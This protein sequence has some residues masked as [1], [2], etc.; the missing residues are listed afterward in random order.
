M[1]AADHG[2]TRALA[3]Y[4]D[5]LRAAA[6]I[7]GVAQ[8]TPVLTSRT[9][10]RLAGASFSFKAENLQRT[11]AFK[12]R[13]AYNAIAAL[14]PEQRRR[15]VV[16]YSSGNHAQAMACAG[17]LLGVPTTVIM[18]HDAPHIKVAATQG[19]GAKVISYDRFAESREAIGRRLAEQEG[20]A[21]VPP[22]DHDD[23]IAGQGTATK[24]L[25]ETV[26]PLDRL[27]VCLG[28][29]GLL[30]GALL[31]AQALAPQCEVFGVEPE[32]GDDGRQSLRKGE[33]VTIPV[34][35]TIADGAMTAF[36]GAR[37]F[38][39]I[40]QHVRDIVTIPDEALAASMRFFA[41]RMKLIVEPTGCLAAAAAFA[42]AD[43][44]A[45]M[46]VGVIISGGNVDLARFSALTEAP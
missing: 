28:G 27:Y 45:G 22:Y 46:R 8:R 40:K 41:E 33:I 9:A 21:L 14:G 4:E 3:T 35:K 16:T 2:E 6:R 1:D 25:F 38:P 11:G 23:V 32:A 24:E 36:L 10:N 26:G 7:E 12:F 17:G 37:S 44:I 5:V 43:E 19:Y 15:G 18:P 34:P 39:I 20:L 30:A 31:A 42:A 13:G 29:G